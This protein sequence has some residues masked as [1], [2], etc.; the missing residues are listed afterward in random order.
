MPKFGQVKI[1]LLKIGGFL[2][3]AFF[4]VEEEVETGL[5]FASFAAVLIFP[6]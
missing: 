3:N 2:F 1:K 6:C 5:I 4:Y